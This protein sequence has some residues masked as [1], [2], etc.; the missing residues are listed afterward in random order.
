MGAEFSGDRRQG[1]KDA[2]LQLRVPHF[3]HAHQARIF[4]TLDSRR[5]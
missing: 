5:G 1:G 4:E 2:Q 3:E